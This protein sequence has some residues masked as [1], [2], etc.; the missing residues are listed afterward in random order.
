MLKEKCYWKFK[1]FFPFCWT[2]L[3]TLIKP[4]T[5]R[6]F[7]IHLYFSDFFF[8]CKSVPPGRQMFVPRTSR[9][10]PLKILFDPPKDLL[11]RRP[12]DVPIWRPED[13]L[14][15]LLRDVLIWRS[16]DVR[17]R[18]IR[19][20]SYRTFRILKN[21]CLKSLLTFLSELIRLAKSNSISTLKVYWEPSKTSKMEHFLQN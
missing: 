9:G 7:P 17:E 4:Y 16:R 15:W 12:W 1:F 5:I 13:V 14:K 18:L 6:F 21:G 2:S 10:R 19:D 8:S 11:I 20:F 3:L